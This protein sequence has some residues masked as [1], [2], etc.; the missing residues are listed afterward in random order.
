MPPPPPCSDHVTR[1]RLLPI[2]AGLALGFVFAAVAVLAVLAVEPWNAPGPAAGTPNPVPRTS[3]GLAK[4]RQLY[5]D[6]CADCHGKKG[7]GDGGGGADLERRPTDLTASPVQTQT[8]GSL[9][10]KITEGR[11]PMPAYRRKLSDEQRWQV[12]HFLRS[13]APNN[14][15]LPENRNSPAQPQNN[16]P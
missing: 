6:R 11:R 14:K 7:R 2:P 12:V 8:D 3:D 15:P 4:G 16:P 1:R 5:A 9:F 10:W 13:L